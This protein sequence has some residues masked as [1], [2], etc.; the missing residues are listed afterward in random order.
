MSKELFNKYQFLRYLEEGITNEIENGNINDEDDLRTYIDQELDN[1][2]IYYRDCFE[3]AMELNATS[4]DGWELGTANDI[5][6]L[7]YFAL[8]EYVYEE[9]DIN[10]FENLIIERDNK[11]NEE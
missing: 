5:C 1:A 8:Y 2:V 4:F 9:I 7:A 10:E 3:I 6:Q 11:E